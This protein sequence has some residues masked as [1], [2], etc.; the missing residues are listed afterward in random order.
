MFAGLPL[1][2]PVRNLGRR[3]VRTCLTGFACALVA[4]VIVAVFSFVH[5][6]EASFTTQSRTD[7]AI[8]LSSASMRDIVRS[9]ISPAVADLVAA[10]VPGILRVHGVAA[11]SPE[12]HMGTNLRLGTGNDARTD[13]PP[14]AAFVRGVTDR[15]FLVHEAVTLVEGRPPGTGEVIVGRLAAAKLGVAGAALRPGRKIRF[16]GG[17]WTIAGTFAAAGTATESEVWVPLHELKSHAQRDDVSCVFVRVARAEAIED[18]AVFAQRRLDLALLCI[19][20]SRY[21]GELAGYFEPIRA[22][23]WT[24]AALIGLTVVFTGANTLNTTVQER[25]RELATLR[26]VGYGGTALVSSLLSEALLLASAGGLAGLILARV[27]VAGSAFRIGMG[28]FALEVTGGAVLAGLAGVLLIGV[29]GTLPA[30][31]RVLHM[32]VAKALAED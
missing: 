24:M 20:T 10:D 2:Y 28:A 14:L 27:A 5:G 31:F 13:D 17:E 15:A 12:I 1:D 21:Y 26:A 29:L 4:A 22:L 3:P 11:V 16:E 23:A 32:S 30:S 8:L 19:P 7:T 18:V 9:A 25:I 6:L